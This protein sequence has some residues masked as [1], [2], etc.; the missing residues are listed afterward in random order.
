MRTAIGD[1][2]I[3]I[4]TWLNEGRDPRRRAAALDELARRICTAVEH[5]AAGYE[6]TCLAEHALDRAV[7]LQHF[8]ALVAAGDERR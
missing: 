4:E 6:P 5:L 2:V 8:I 3:R 7:S 1:R